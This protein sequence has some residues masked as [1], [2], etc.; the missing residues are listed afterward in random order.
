MSEKLFQAM[1][2]ALDD[3]SKKEFEP[4]FVERSRM[5]RQLEA[6]DRVVKSAEAFIQDAIEMAQSEGQ[7]IWR[8]TL[9]LK[10]DIEAYEKARG[11]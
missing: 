3:W 2:E 7:C 10:D 6:A 4:H 8:K 9:A 1:R 11:G 5:K